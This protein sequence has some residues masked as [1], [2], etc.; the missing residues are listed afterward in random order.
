M[1]ELHRGKQSVVFP[2]FP[3]IEANA[4]I[5][6]K[7][8]GEGPLREDFDQITQDTKLNQASWEKAE[9]ELQK[10]ALE[11]ALGKASLNYDD[12]DVLFAGDLLNQC[13]SSRRAGAITSSHFA[14]AERQY[15][16]PLGYGGQR[17]PTAQWTVTGSGCC[18]VSSS[19]K[20]PFVEC[21]TVGKI[22]DFGIK[23]ANNMG[24]AM[25]P[26][27]VDTIRQHFED[28]G[29]RPQDYDLIVTGDLGV[30]GKQIVLEQMKLDGFDLTG[31]YDDCGVMIFDSVRQDVHAG[32]SGCGCSASVLCGHL[33]RRMREGKLK[34]LLFCAT[35][36][37]LSPVSSWQ[38]ESI[39]GVCHAVS[40]VSERR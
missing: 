21:A 11:L 35:G 20:G 33:L 16:F 29:R 17:T 38:G 1:Q 32:G 31:R 30:L 34:R 18:I 10:T 26:A 2:N 5:V 24:A 27:A 8:E 13:I 22:Q 36:A 9:S 7:K 19:G 25:A 37:L 6:G 3:A 12:L 28:F 39:P 14:S 40:I 23:D 15:R 4:A